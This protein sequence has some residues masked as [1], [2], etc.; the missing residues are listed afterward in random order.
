MQVNCQVAFA[1]GGIGGLL[2]GG[3]LLQSFSVSRVSVFWAVGWVKLALLALLPCLYDRLV[4]G[5]AACGSLRR[6][7]YNVWYNVSLLRVIGSVVFV[8]AFAAAPNNTDAFLTYILQDTPLC[9]WQAQACHSRVVGDPGKYEDYCSAF[10]GASACGTQWGGLGFTPA[11]FAYVGLVG[12]LG[13]VVGS[14]TF[15]AWL[16]HRGWHGLFFATVVVSALASA[17]QLLLMFRDQLGRT[18]VERWGIDNFYFAL[19]D[20]AVNAAAQ[21]L[22]ALPILILMARMC[23]P[24][25]E[26]TFYAVVT[27]VQSIGGTVSGAFSQLA[28]RGFGVSLADFSGLWRLTLLTST[29]KLA[30]LLFLPLVPKDITHAADADDD[31][32][33]VFTGALVSLLAGGGLV[34]A[35][36]D[37]AAS[38]EAA[39]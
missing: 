19:A 28:T 1:M 25:A 7:A 8:F 20:D 32:R 22:L 10:A 6:A 26:G 38:V 9:V 30:V 5:G 31:R 27:S 37:A 16:Q 36:C 21:Q 24:G 18:F 14:L 35:V 11:M 13:S 3:Y 4:R 29:V 2:L 15:K 12:G 33:S 39:S 17:S 23:P 34:Y